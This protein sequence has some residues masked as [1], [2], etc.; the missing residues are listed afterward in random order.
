MAADAPFGPGCADVPTDGEGSV[1]GMADDPVATAASN[2]PLLT[3]LVAAVT[4]AELVDTL[5]SAEGITVFA[6]TDDAFAKIPKK[7]LTRCSPT[8]KALTTVLTHHVVA[9]ELSPR[10][11]RGRARDP[12]RRHDHRRGLGRGLHRRGRDRGVRQ[13]ADRQRHRVRRRLGHDARDVSR[14][15]DQPITA[16]ITD[17]DQLR[18]VPDGAP[19]GAPSR[20]AAGAARR[21]APARQP[22]RRSGLRRVLRRDLGPG[23][24]PRASRG[25][26][27]GPCRGG[28]PGG[29][30]RRL[31][32]QHPL[33]LRT[34]ERSRL[35][36]DHRAPQGRRP[37][38]LGR[39]GHR[40]RRD[41]APRDRSRSTTTRPPR[42]PTP[43][44]RRPGS[45]EQSPP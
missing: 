14:R 2:N 42:P 12:G 34:R 9:G 35:A 3:T 30:P 7:D 4:E 23:L 33:R 15:P 40:P 6:P 17:V 28:H 37:G 1:E 44:S 5:N 11:R 31:A 10:G 38:P 29:L 43:R 26:Q 45:A 32:V 19:Q 39:G 8:R 16:R 20:G 24:R 21:P 41:V 22:G 18:P 13:R 25:P 27:P 36:A